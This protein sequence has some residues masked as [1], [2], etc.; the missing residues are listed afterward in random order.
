MT[1]SHAIS[2]FVLALAA[3]RN[4]ALRLPSSPSDAGADADPLHGALDKFAN[5]QLTMQS[6]LQSDLDDGVQ[7]AAKV[8]ESITSNRN[9]SKSGSVVI[10]SWNKC[11]RKLEH[12]GAHYTDSVASKRYNFLYF[13]NVKA[14]SSSIRYMLSKFLKIDWQHT[15]IEGARPTG[16]RFSSKDFND[17]THMFKFSVVRDPIAKFESG[18]RQAR[19]QNSKYFANMTADEILKDVMAKGYF[20]NEHLQPSSF[21]LSAYDASTPP[22]MHNLDFIGKV[23]DI[24]HDWS[25]IVD[26]MKGIGEGTK[27]QMK[28]LQKLN[29]R[30]EDPDTVLSEAAIQQMC[31]SDMYRF[32][33]ECF[34]YDLPKVCQE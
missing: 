13:D 33:W 9:F 3:Y 31:N 24:E 25:I 30:V 18:V 17:T 4:D 6:D 8:G 14:A 7:W 5:S 28:T 32:E 22:S 15:D 19:F 10:Q 27:Q 26:A 12:Y 29:S 2:S 23:E 20:T 11:K 34:G 21:R 16:Q 1:L